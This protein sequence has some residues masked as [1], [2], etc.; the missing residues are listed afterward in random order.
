MCGICFILGGASIHS[1]DFSQYNFFQAYLKT[2]D[3]LPLNEHIIH[4]KLLLPSSFD[5][6]KLKFKLQERGPDSFTSS[7]LDMFKV[8]SQQLDI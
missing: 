3:C 1:H 7:R 8:M 2:A 4:N 5:P 6:S